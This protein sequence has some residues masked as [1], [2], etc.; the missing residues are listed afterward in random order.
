VK[1]EKEEKKITRVSLQKRTGGQKNSNIMGT[2]EADV[3]MHVAEAAAST[4][5]SSSVVACDMAQEEVGGCTAE[6][7]AEA[8]P[9][10]VQAT[11]PQSS[12]KKK[13]SDKKPKD[14]SSKKPLQSPASSGWRGISSYL[15]QRHFYLFSLGQRDCAQREQIKMHIFCALPRASLMQ[16]GC[17]S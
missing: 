11:T 6:G 4:V 9:V 8:S 2:S 1:E 3:V 12:A 13:L 17:G 15:V 14:S 16:H 7:A 10:K 5:Q